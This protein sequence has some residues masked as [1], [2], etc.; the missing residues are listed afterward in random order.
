MNRFE[1][2]VLFFIQDRVKDPVKL[3]VNA[4]I[5]KE[6]LNRILKKLEKLGLIKTKKLKK[7]FQVEITE[8]GQEFFDNKIRRF[9]Y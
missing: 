6:D 7:N 5:G 2:D 4:D 8:K 3:S 1:K 9:Y